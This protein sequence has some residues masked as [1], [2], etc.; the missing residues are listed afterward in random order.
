MVQLNDEITLVGKTELRNQFPK[1][2]KQLKNKKV[3]VMQRG[4]PIAVLQ[5]FEEYQRNEALL[6]EAED[7]ILGLLAKKRWEDPKA[8]YIDHETAKKMLGIKD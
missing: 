7:L 3:F 2:E 5:D 6:E 4:Q 1:L 8:Q